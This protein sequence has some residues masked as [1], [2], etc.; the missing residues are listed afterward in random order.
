MNKRSL[1]R[2]ISLIMLFIAIVFV[3]I[4]LGH[5]ELG[6]VFYI[7]SIRIGAKECRMFYKAYLIIMV[8]IFAS[9]FFVKNSK[10]EN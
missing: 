7:G 9:S 5:P 1:L 4:A 8:L 3:V 6:S 2:I 10:K